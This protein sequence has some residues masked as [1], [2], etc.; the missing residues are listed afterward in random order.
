[1]RAVQKRVSAWAASILRPP[2]RRQ[3]TL[4]STS[5]SVS[6]I[7]AALAS[8]SASSVMLLDSSRPTRQHPGTKPE[9]DK[10]SQ[11]SSHTSVCGYD[12]RACLGTSGRLRFTS[13][14]CL[15]VD[16]PINAS[17][18]ALD[19]RFRATAHIHHLLETLAQKSSSCRRTIPC[20]P[21]AHHAQLLRKARLR[22]L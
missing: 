17:V 5:V 16:E 8:F 3:S 21:R 13:Q 10:I 4:L 9:E 12:A 19:K 18:L 1:M 11:S 2:R 7:I 14:N 20:P 6:L 22:S 15:T